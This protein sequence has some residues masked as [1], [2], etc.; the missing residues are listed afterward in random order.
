MRSGKRSPSHFTNWCLL[1]RSVSENFKFNVLSVFIL[2]QKDQ[3]FPSRS[4]HS[5]PFRTSILAC[6]SPSSTSVLPFFPRRKK[7]YTSIAHRA[8]NTWTTLT[9]LP[10]AIGPYSRQTSVSV[11]PLDHM[12]H[13]SVTVGTLSTWKFQQRNCNSTRGCTGKKRSPPQS[14]S[15]LSPFVHQRKPLLRLSSWRVGT[16]TTGFR[17]TTDHPPPRRAPPTSLGPWRL[18]MPQH[19]RSLF[20]SRAERTMVVSTA[21]CRG[22]CSHALQSEPPHLPRTQAAQ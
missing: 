4:H 18:P 19:P 9:C 13:R 6:N 22:I 5:F 1:Q 21:S 11:V 20:H 2:R 17:S 10:E 14:P 8:K 7:L 15:L 16:R 12:R 3:V